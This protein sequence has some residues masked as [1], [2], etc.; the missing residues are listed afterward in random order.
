[1]RNIYDTETVSTFVNPT[2]MKSLVNFLLKISYTVLQQHQCATLF[3]NTTSFNTVTSTLFTN[4]LRHNKQEA[5]TFVIPPKNT[6]IPE[7]F[8]ILTQDGIPLDLYLLSK[9]N[10]QIV[11]TINTMPEYIS[12]IVMN[13]SKYIRPNLTFIDQYDFQNTMVRD[14]LVRSYHQLK[15]TWVSSSILK[16][17]AKLYGVILSGSISSVFNLERTVQQ[18]LNAVFMNLFLTSALDKTQASK[19]M[20]VMNSSFY[21]PPLSELKDVLKLIDDTCPNGLTTLTDAFKVSK[22]FT[23]DRVILDKALLLSRNQKIGPDIPTSSLALE[24][25]PY[26]VYIVLLGLSNVKIG[27]SYKIK[28]CLLKTEIAELTNYF[29]YPDLPCVADVY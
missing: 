17:C 16:I 21:L 24:F 10:P 3:K 13:G 26:F 27:I 11:N 23:P 22:N 12:K 19:I 8:Q 4:I 6:P 15:K 28:D 18:K 14:I 7:S 2:L 9:F 20:L 29:K 25:P 5:F 1:M